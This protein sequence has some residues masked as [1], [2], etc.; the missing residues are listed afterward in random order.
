MTIQMVWGI[1]TFVGVLQR[2]AAVNLLGRAAMNLG[3]PVVAAFVICVIAALA[4]ALAST[5]GILAA[6]VPM[7]VPLAISGGVSGWA[8]I[9]SAAEDKRSPLESLLTRWGLAISR[10]PRALR[11]G[12]R[13]P[14]SGPASTRTDH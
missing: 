9:A 4:S 12:R 6:L 1:A 13:A 8:M 3:T 7:A 2:M 10:A 14:A 5:T 11:S